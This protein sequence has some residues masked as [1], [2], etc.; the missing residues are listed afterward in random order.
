MSEHAFNTNSLKIWEEKEILDRDYFVLSTVSDVTKSLQN[1]NKAW[2]FFRIE[3][4]CLM[5]EEFLNKEYTEKEVFKTSKNF[6][7]RPETTASSY[8]MAKKYLKEKNGAKFPFCVWQHGKSF[9][10]EANDGATSAKLRFNEFYQLEFQCFYSESSKC[11]YMSYLLSDIQQSMLHFL[12]KE[13]RITQSDRIPS[14]SEKT[15][16]LECLYNNKTMELASCSIRNDFD[17]EGIKVL[18]MAIG[19]DR[20]ISVMNKNYKNINNC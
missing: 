20:V 6:C 16:D 12:N 7:L 1:L 2:Q 19:T 11:D 4:S 8:Y 9:R 10:V 5:P 17:I 18:E 15:Y 3:G 14:Y 13:I